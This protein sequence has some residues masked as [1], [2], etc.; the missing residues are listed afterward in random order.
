MVLQCILVSYT[1]VFFLQK[2]RR[3]QYSPILT[4]DLMFLVLGNK[5]LHFQ[6][7]HTNITVIFF[8]PHFFYSRRKRMNKIKKIKFKC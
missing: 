4:F 3:K 6:Q 1:K 2:K 5:T 7:M 8:Y